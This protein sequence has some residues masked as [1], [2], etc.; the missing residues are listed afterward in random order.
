MYPI[1]T[2]TCDTCDTDSG[3]SDP[4]DIV[5]GHPNNSRMNKAHQSP[6][7]TKNLKSTYPVHT[8][9]CDTCDM[10]PGGLDP[11]DPGEQGPRGMVAHPNGLR[12]N[13]SLMNGS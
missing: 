12:L 6:S 7:R 8:D 9:T 3:G 5:A 11:V 2:D 10:D 1:H 13:H 4:V